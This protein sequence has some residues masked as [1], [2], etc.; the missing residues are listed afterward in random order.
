MKYRLII[1]VLLTAIA[2][3]NAQPRQA[4]LKG[5]LFIIGGGNRT[6]ALMKT[7][8]ATGQKRLCGRAAYEQCRA[9]QL[10]FLF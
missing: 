9:R 10:V 8:L 4:A 6:A 5:R 7:M 1:A 3:A 2:A